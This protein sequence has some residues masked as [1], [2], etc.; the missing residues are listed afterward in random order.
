MQGSFFATIW[1]AYA[2]CHNN[3]AAHALVMTNLEKC[4]IDR[5]TAVLY[6]DGAQC[7]E[8]FSTQQQR[9]KAR[10]KATDAADKHQKTLMECIAKGGRIRKRHF[11]NINKGLTSAFRWDSEARNGLALFLRN[12]GWTVVQ[13]ETE[14]DVRIAA[15]TVQGDIVISGDSDLFI[16][17]HITVVWRPVRGGG[18][19]EYRKSDVLSALGFKSAEQLNALGVVSTNDY[20]HSGCETNY[21]IIEGLNAKGSDKAKDVPTLVKE[22]LADERVVFKNK[23]SVTFDT[24]IKVFVHLQQ[25]PIATGHHEQPDDGSLE[26][27][28]RGI[29]KRF[30]DACGKFEERK[31]A[32]LA[33][34]QA[35]NAESVSSPH[36]HRSSQKFN[37]YRT[38]DHP[39]PKKSE[40]PIA[41]PLQPLP[42]PRYSV[43]TREKTVVYEPPKG[44]KRYKW[45]PWVKPPE[46]PL[47]KE[48]TLKPKSTKKPSRKPKKPPT[49]IEFMNK[50][51]LLSA[52]TWEHPRATLKIGT[53][54]ANIRM[55]LNPQMDL[56]GEMIACLREAVGEANKTK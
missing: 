23:G 11:V 19:L 1:Y 25:T 32:Q 5:A 37:R 12:R 6:F 22:Y 33:S 35:I 20:N 2:H 10:A 16:Y 47:E 52:L 31:Q 38:I 53:L 50:K 40:D 30:N 24:S 45:K 36:R 9:Q 4:A 21:K 15:D 56:A 41:E 46:S 44:L 13:C 8:K 34:R 3:E 48:S 26:M 51:E 28:L 27:R 14:A 17:Q 39:P 55:A 43:K 29:K 42:R 54:Q 18:F 49:P 7:E